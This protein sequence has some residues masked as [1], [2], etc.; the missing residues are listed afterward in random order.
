MTEPAASASATDASLV[1]TARDAR[2]VVTLT[3]ADPARLN[4]LGDS[5]LSA[6]QQALDAVAQDTQARVVVLAA[7]GKA[8]CA[9]HDLK[10]MAAHPDAAWYKRLFAQCSRM[11]VSIQRL[12]VPVIARV[13]GIATAAGCQL[14]A[15]CDLAVAAEGA[16]FATS[17]I[18]YGLFCATPSVPLVRN[19]PAKR[20]MEMLLTGD[21]IDARTALA[22]G[23]VN[24]VAS[25]EA[26]DAE[27]E[28]LVRSIL[29]KPR[30]AVA[31]GKAL[32]YQQRELGVEAA[33]QLAG[34]A[35]A[36]NMMDEAAQEGARAFAEKRVPAWKTAGEPPPPATR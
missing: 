27:V 26:L 31:M 29:E 24:R 30:A 15:Q 18:H 7:Q 14:V 9:G 8:F 3:L 28:S 22:E 1:H 32:F 25:P 11:M 13:Q 20:A 4:A 12:P 34:Q 2:G 5:M 36:T 23:L 6:L 17:G 10:D 19:V 16:R 21:F 35:M 33:Y